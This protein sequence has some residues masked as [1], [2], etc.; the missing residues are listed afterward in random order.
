MN[1]AFEH[2]TDP[3]GDSPR[4]ECQPGGRRG[5]QARRTRASRTRASRTWASRTWA[6]RTWAWRLA[7]VALVAT[8]WAAEP[9]EPIA[10]GRWSALP[11]LPDGL[12]VAGA[13]AGVVG[14]VLVVAG[15]ANFPGR[16]PWAGGEKVWHDR[17][18]LLRSPEDSWESGPSLPRP[19]AYGVAISLAEGLLCA[20]GSDAT[21]H[22]AE[23]FLLEAVGDRIQRRTLPPLPHPLAN[24]CGARVGR[25]IM[26]AGGSDQ[27]GATAALREFLAFDLATPTARW[28]RLE[29]WPGP[30]RILGVAAA[31]GG[32]FL[33]FSGA[34]LE[35]DGDGKAV[36]RY[37]RDAYRY[38]SG[39]GWKRLADVPV[40]VV[41]APSPALALGASRIV[42]LGGDDGTRVGFQPLDQHPGFSKRAW[43]YDTTTDTWTS[44]GEA[45]VAQVTTPAVTWRGRWVIPSGEVR[46][47]VRS[48]EVWA[49]TPPRA[50]TS[51]PT[52]SPRS[53]DRPTPPAPP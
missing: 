51:R 42:V 16:M 39:G 41:A 3:A 1:L 12:G 33:L 32:A 17:V 38:S 5:C 30:G 18:Y 34:A 35:A 13:F 19:L 8:G 31:Q 23:V 40:P 45:P 53:A 9:T 10:L 6:S 15:G 25:T 44:W 50:P 11:P 28:Q 52:Y 46:P 7:L 22:S 4:A 24:A 14:D 26:I 47:G 49:M 20:G 37:L 29:P 21:G 36:R 27:P 48:P 2:G 43:L